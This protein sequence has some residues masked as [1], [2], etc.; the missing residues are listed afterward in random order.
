MKHLILIL[1]IGIAGLVQAQNNSKLDKSLTKKLPQDSQ[2]DGRWVYY[3]ENANIQPIE[4]PLVKAR[5][6]NYNFYQVNLTNYLGYHVNE[7]ECLILFNPK[8]SKIILVA[9]LWFSGV[10]ANY[11]KLIIGEGFDN[12]DSLLN[13][14]NEFHELMGVGS[15][16]KFIL[17]SYK[18][19]LITYDMV[20]LKGD[21]YTT[22]SPGIQSTVSYSEDGVWRKIQIKISDLKIKSYTSINPKMGEGYIIK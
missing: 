13:F 22:S 9:P 10:D 19:D 4:K 1:F 20:Y 18:D 5:I 17:T 7:A 2:K 11:V 21:S 6:P 3:S 16:Y 12:K 14:L 15:G 8:K